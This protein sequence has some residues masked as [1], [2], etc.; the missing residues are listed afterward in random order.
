[1]F[2]DPLTAWV[3]SLLT[4][5]VALAKE[6]LE[7]M[8]TPVIPA[9]NW[10]NK[11]LIKKDRK[12][13]LTY[14]EI[15]DNAKKGRYICVIKYD[16]PHR[17]SKGKIIIENCELYHEDVKIYGACNAQKWTKQGKYNLNVE[18]LK[19]TELQFEKKWIKI[20]GL[21]T[22]MTHERKVRLEEIDRLL[23]STNWDFRHTESAN[24][25]QKV[26]DINSSK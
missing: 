21:T 7:N 20:Y 12:C 19:I 22:G 25:W 2:F 11:E 8:C 18:E 10:D 26:Y 4:T 16:E 14:D 23:A 9:E 17:D 6:K 24:H 13:G 1:M 3:V 15:R 5:G